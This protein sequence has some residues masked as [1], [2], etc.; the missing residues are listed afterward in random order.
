[1]EKG[2]CLKRK[3]FYGIITLTEKGQIAIPIDIRR[4][5]DLKKGEKLVVIKREDGKG[6]N[7]IKSD[8]IEGLINKLSKD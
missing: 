1:M 2:T 6:I 3:K 4:D 8:E 5:L 7:L